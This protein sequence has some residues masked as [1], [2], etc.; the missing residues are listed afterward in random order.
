MAVAVASGFGLG[1]SPFAPGTVGTVLGVPLAMMNAR[2]P[3]LWQFACA[4]VLALLAVPV[5]DAAE[6]EF[7]VKDDRR[8]VAD[9]FLTFPLVVAGLPCVEK[10]WLLLLGFLTHRLMDVIKPPPARR[11]QEMSGGLGVAGDDIV[12][13]VY[14]LALNHAIWA[15]VSHFI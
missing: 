10:P 7:G 3:V 5:C 11:V 13:A 14:A 4:I 15:G 2:I 1:F 6:K 8:I 9:E 12:S